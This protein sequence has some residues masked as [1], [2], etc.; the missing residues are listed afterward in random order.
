MDCQPLIVIGALPLGLAN[1]TSTLLAPAR[2]SDSAI[3]LSVVVNAAIDT[4]NDRNAPLD[5]VFPEFGRSSTAQLAKRQV[6]KTKSVGSIHGI[7]LFQLHG[8]SFEAICKAVS[9]S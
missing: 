2:H 8:S 1:L 3:W 6:V 5:G 7:T 4:G 9:G